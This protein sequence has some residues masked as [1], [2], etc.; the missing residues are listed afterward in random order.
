MELDKRD[1]G[2]LAVK[3]VLAGAT[4]LPFFLE[5]D[6]T[7]KVKCGYYEVSSPVPNLSDFKPENFREVPCECMQELYK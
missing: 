4:A 1:I 6:Y 2:K 3:L 5:P 7:P